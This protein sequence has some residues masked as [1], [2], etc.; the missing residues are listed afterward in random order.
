MTFDDL[1]VLCMLVVIL[2]IIV[3]YALDRHGL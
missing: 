1:F 3:R 2:A